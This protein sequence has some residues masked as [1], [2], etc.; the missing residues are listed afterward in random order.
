MLALN[1]PVDPDCLPQAVQPCSTALVCVSDRFC[2]GSQRIDVTKK[3]AEMTSSVRVRNGSPLCRPAFVQVDVAEL[4]TLARCTSKTV[5]FTSVLA[6]P[7][8]GNHG[9]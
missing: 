2:N 5:L 9:G 8:D 3:P 1:L 7:G 6:M 4:I